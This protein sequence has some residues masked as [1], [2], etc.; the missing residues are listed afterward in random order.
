MGIDGL[1]NVNQTD[2]NLP[3]LRLGEKNTKPG[4]D[5]RI[6]PYPTNPPHWCF[7][8]DEVPEV[9]EVYGEKPKSI[10]VIFLGRTLEE[11]MSSGYSF[12]TATTK[13]AWF[14]TCF[15]NG[16]EAAWRSKHKVE[17]RESVDTKKLSATVDGKVFSDAFPRSGC[18]RACPDFRSGDCKMNARIRVI[19]PRVSMTRVY[20]I[21]TSA[22]H[23]IQHFVS[24]AQN[25]ER[26]SSF[27]YSGGVPPA[28]TLEKHQ[29]TKRSLNEAET[30]LESHDFRYL[31][32]KRNESFWDVH[33][34]DIILKYK[35]ASG[36]NFKKRLLLEV[37][38]NTNDLQAEALKQVQAANKY[39][40]QAPVDSYIYQDDIVNQQTGEI[41]QESGGYSVESD[42]EV[43]AAV[44][45]VLDSA[46]LKFEKDSV[47]KAM[48]K[49][50]NTKE[51]IKAGVDAYFA[52]KK[53]KA[54][55][56]P[57]KVEKIVETSTTTPGDSL[58]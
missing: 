11:I 29:E 21:V 5:G 55:S 52:S 43:I 25:L 51:Q 57:P 27:G 1:T 2:K 31:I 12:I 47:K 36:A 20:E 28:F 46:N 3:K 4:K 9:V 23:S 40:L 18:G 39:Q 58:L 45:S 10:E 41:I 53:S 14:T 30:D 8:K 34:E 49:Y 48:A 37:G 13:K 7:S 42:P 19:L 50:G 35:A 44:K 16:V 17:G 32:S 15:G 54:T 33:G 38:V 56:A 24:L 22:Y 6:S 26:E